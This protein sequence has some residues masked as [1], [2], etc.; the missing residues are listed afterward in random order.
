MKNTI[1]CAIKEF[2]TMNE[3][4]EYLSNYI[5]KL[6]KRISNYDINYSTLGTYLDSLEIVDL[7]CEI[8]EKYNIT[9]DVDSFVWEEMKLET[10]VKYIKNK[11][12]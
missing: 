8:E 10:V 7:I 4:K 9:I 5:K 6:D 3:I 11:L 12:G 1:I 2:K